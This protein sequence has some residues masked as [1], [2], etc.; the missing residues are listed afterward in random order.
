MFHVVTASSDQ[1]ALNTFFTWKHPFCLSSSYAHWPISQEF[2]YCSH[3]HL[4]CNES[5]LGLKAAYKFLLLELVCLDFPFRVWW[6]LP[7]IAISHESATISLH[8]CS[9]SCREPMVPLQTMNIYSQSL[10]RPTV[11]CLVQTVTLNYAL[12]RC[13]HDDKAVVVCK[14]STV[15]PVESLIILSACHSKWL[16]MCT[17]R[18]IFFSPHFVVFKDHQ[19]N[20]WAV[21]NYKPPL[22]L[23]FF[24]QISESTER[25]LLPWPILFLAFRLH[26]C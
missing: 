6:T 22:K 13:V 9:R 10:V 20:M 2:F 1:L 19:S 25:V 21:V 23:A 11:C 18:H 16:A 12:A 17:A 24:M 3:W 14:F 15:V 7:V 26:F 5:F 8:E 4:R